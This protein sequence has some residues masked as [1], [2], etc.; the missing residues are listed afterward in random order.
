MT[1]P[2]TLQPA[3][4][5]VPRYQHKW[6]GQS[7]ISLPSSDSSDDEDN[8]YCCFILLLLYEVFVLTTPLVPKCRKRALKQTQKK[9]KKN[10]PCSST[11]SD[12]PDSHSGVESPIDDGKAMSDRASEDLIN[13]LSLKA[14]S[15]SFQLSSPS[16]TGEGKL[17]IYHLTVWLTS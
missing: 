15:N 13:H 11:S 12:K 3:I 16:V 8:F 4:G 7:G 5:P 10:V 6:N 14:I 9:Q 2:E 1:V 17:C